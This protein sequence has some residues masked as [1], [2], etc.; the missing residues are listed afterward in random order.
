MAIPDE[1]RERLS[2]DPFMSKCC[3][4]DGEC[5]GRIEWNHALLFAGRRQQF[6][7]SILPMCSSH[8]SKTDRYDIRSKVNAIMRERSGGELEKFEKVKKWV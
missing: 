5:G 1:T 2:A 7:W 6:W 8:H 3:V 4:Q